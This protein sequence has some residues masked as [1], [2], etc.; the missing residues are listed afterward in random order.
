MKVAP[1]T[2]ASMASESGPKI[3]ESR[4]RIE[5]VDEIGQHGIIVGGMFISNNC[6]TILLVMSLLFIIGGRES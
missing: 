2:Q 1:E 5:K 3:Q 6:N 4:F